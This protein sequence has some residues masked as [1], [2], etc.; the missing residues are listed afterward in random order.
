MLNRRGLITG[1]VSFVA[2]PAIVRAASLM[3][4]KAIV[5]DELPLYGF[6]PALAALLRDM[7][8]YN[9]SAYMRPPAPL[10]GSPM[11]EAPQGLKIGDR[12]RLRSGGH[13]N[14]GDFAIA[15]LQ[16]IE[17]AAK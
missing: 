1:L 2:A 3:P 16:V 6:S 10:L 17:G 12:V 9:G 15:A 5:L 4:V 11:S 14:S 13:I 8:E 7:E